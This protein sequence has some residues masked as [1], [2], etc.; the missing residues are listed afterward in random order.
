M[1]QL[2]G[3]DSLFV[4]METSEV[5]AHVG[6]LIIL[7]PTEA[8]SFSFDRVARNLA[9]RLNLAGPEFVS[10]LA[11]APLGL[12]RPYLMEDESFDLSRHLHRIA[13]P[14]PGGMRELADLCGYL[15]EQKLDR[16]RA[17]WEMWFIEGVELD[18]EPAAAIYMKT[19]HAL[20]D[21]MKGADL[22]VILCDLEPEPADPPTPLPTKPTTEEIPSEFS[23]ALEG[24][25]NLVTLPGAVV[26]YGFQAL[27]RGAN[28][29]PYVLEHGT[30]G[31]PGAAPRL[32]FNAELG[33][34]RRFAYTSLP[35]DEVK[36]I[37]GVLGVKLNDVVIG[38]CGAA[39]RKYA[40][41][42][43]EELNASL[44]VSCPVST[45]VKGDKESSNKVAHMVVSCATDIDDP[46]ERVRAIHQSATLAKEV[47]SRLRETA[48]PSL[49]EVL[50]PALINLGFRTL[51]GL[52]EY[53]GTLPTN[54]VV[55]NVPGPPVPLYIAGARVH[56]VFPISVLAPTQGLNFTAVSFVGRLD[57]GVTTDPEMIP[58]A[59]VL[60][61]C[62]DEAFAELRDAALPTAEETAP[63]RASHKR[64]AGRLVIPERSIAAA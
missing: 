45:R 33:P 35:L 47:T 36:A 10:R 42:N 7:D 13:V 34:G 22:S 30:E 55:S 26:G 6:G 25:T 44:A 57:I 37:K 58:D 14:S 53:T 40:E 29:I 39:M 20:M 61:E 63:V 18:G 43:G 50:P 24:F 19:H 27:R 52:A 54:A 56:R 60:A 5:H 4:S 21:G 62:L 17:L 32:S 23:R 49:G 28:M 31:L 15:H 59:W 11:E 8:K 16:R 1:K 41:R 51:S 46:V 9:A 38:L 3:T 48:I 64:P 2:S 12:A